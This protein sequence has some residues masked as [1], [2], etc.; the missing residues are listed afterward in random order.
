MRRNLILPFLWILT[1]L[2]CQLTSTP[3]APAVS[4]TPLSTNTAYLPITNTVTPPIPSAT[5]T[6]SLTPTSTLTETP[7]PTETAIPIPSDTALP[8]VDSLNAQVTANRLSCRYGPGP[9][10]LYLFALRA[11]ANIKLIGR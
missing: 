2:A 4:E 6:V 8:T 5:P 10:Y 1:S 7:A 3:I 11:T 9:D